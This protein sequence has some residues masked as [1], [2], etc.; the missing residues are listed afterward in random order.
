VCDV[1]I[2][3]HI[4]Y[5][6]DRQS[7]PRR[8]ECHCWELQDQFLLSVDDLVLLASSEQS[9]ENALDGFSAACDQG[10]MT[11]STEKTEVLCLQKLKPS[12]NTLQQ[13][14]KFKYLRVIF[15]SDGK[16]NKEID[17]RIGKQ[18]QFPRELYRSVFTQ[19]EL[20]NTAKLLV[21]KPVFVQILTYGHECWNKEYYPKCKWQR[22]I[23]ANSTRR[24]IS[25]QS[26]QL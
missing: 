8:R 7:Q 11:I 16:K 17:T 25:R 2:P 1:I 6:L 5:E 13:E 19:R 21:F 12:G 14:E 15:T 4:L 3:L 23:F 20:S 10:G 24:D 26:V 22:W 9:L 18:T